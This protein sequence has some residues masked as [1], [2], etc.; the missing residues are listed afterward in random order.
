MEGAVARKQVVPEEVE[1]RKVLAGSLAGGKQQVA[2]NRVGV[3]IVDG[4]MELLGVGPVLC[5][6][7]EPAGSRLVLGLAPLGNL[8]LV[9]LCI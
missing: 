5:I 1:C 9:V 3:R 6:G 8:E 4:P 7:V 2:L